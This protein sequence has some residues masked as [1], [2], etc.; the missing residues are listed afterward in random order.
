M[1]HIVQEA[2]QDTEIQSVQDRLIDSVTAAEQEAIESFESAGQAVVEGFGRA[3]REIADFIAERIR[4]DL[5]TQ[6][7]YLRC[8]SFD[9]LREINIRFVRTAVDQYGGEASR[10]FKLGGEVAARSLERIRAN[11]P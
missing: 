10:L 9:E 5:D 6:Q 8:R 1:A 7:A 3:Q 11:G 4:Q 2:A